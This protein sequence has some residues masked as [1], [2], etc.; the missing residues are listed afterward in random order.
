MRASFADLNSPR[1]KKQGFLV[2]VV[3]AFGICVGC[4]GLGL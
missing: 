4:P 2:L 3:D 1:I